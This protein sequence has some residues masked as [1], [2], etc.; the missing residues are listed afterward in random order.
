MKNG[1]KRSISF[2]LVAAMGLGLTSPVM[3]ADGFSSA[4]DEARNV[5]ADEI[6][7]ES[8]DENDGLSMKI[9]LEDGTPYY[10]V[11]LNGYNL[12]EKSK[13]GMNTNDIGSFE[14]G[15]S[16]GEVKIKDVE[17]EPWE[18]V[19]GDYASVEDKYQEA[20]IPL[21]NENG[22]LTVEARIY[23]TGVA[24]RYDLPDVPD[25]KED[26]IIGSS[27]EKTQFAFPEGTYAY[28]HIDQNQTKPSKTSVDNL[29]GGIFIVR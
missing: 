6:V 2:L 24:F 4:N 11:T 28:R 5:K 16:M 22:T 23:D 9:W 1:I 12:V 7:L 13:L 3:A 10:T 18:P 15:F 25:G 8:P 26:Y 17:N 19:V 14:N 27:D 29:G 21:T 20:V